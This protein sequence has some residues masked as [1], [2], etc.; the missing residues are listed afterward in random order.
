VQHLR[1]ALISRDSQGSNQDLSSS[2][3]GPSP[4][5][6]PSSQRGAHGGNGSFD[7][8]NTLQTKKKGMS[9]VP[10]FFT[11]KS[12]DNLFASVAQQQRNDASTPTS[13]SR[14]TTQQQSP[15]DYTMPLNDVSSSSSD[16]INAPGIHDGETNNVD[17]TSLK[18]G[19]PLFSG[20]AIVD[21]PIKGWSWYS[22]TGNS[23]S[24]ENLQQRK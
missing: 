11:S 4:S 12:Q 6:S 9:R 10:S 14:Q 24:S 20:H 3:D 15:N 8:Q 5:P 18:C 23:P 7:L 16:V 1:K 13:S 22:N 21:S 17:E 19:A 2:F